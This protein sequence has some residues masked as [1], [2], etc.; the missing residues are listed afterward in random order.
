MYLKGKMRNPVRREIH[1]VK[2]KKAIIFC[3]QVLK[4]CNEI[5]PYFISWSAMSSSG[6]VFIVR[7]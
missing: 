7:L 3:K 5:F 2:V 1:A 6:K 4:V